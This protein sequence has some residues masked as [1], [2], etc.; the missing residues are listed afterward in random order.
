MFE[1]AAFLHSRPA[2]SKAK[3][4]VCPPLLGPIRLGIHFGMLLLM[5]LCYS[6]VT[7]YMFMGT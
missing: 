5:L 3:I 6:W 7:F 2:E 1:L 4:M